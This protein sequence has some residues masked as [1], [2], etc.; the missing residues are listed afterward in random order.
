MRFNENLRNLRREKDMSQEALAC[1]M[2][3]SR[4]TISKWENGTAMPDLK[5]L[6]ELA[7]YFSVSMDTLLGI[8]A[9]SSSEKP[10]DSD[11]TDEGI[12]QYIN[13]LLAY[14][15]I[16]QQSQNKK[17]IKTFFIALAAVVIIFSIALIIFYNNFSEQ[18]TAL[19]VR[20]I[21]V[22]SGNS[23]YDYDETADNIDYK[24]IS[25]HEDKPYTANVHFEYNPESYPKNSE[26]YYLIPQSDSDA[27][28]IDAV[29]N[30]GVFTADADVDITLNKEIYLCIDDVNTVE[31]KKIV[32]SFVADCFAVTVLTTPF[33]EITYG[34][35]NNNMQALTFDPSFTIDNTLYLYK[36][37]EGEFTSA[38]LVAACSGKEQFSKVLTF[39]KYTPEGDDTQGNYIVEIPAVSF[40]LPLDSLPNEIIYISLTDENGTEYKYYPCLEDFNFG[41]DDDLCE[42]VFNTDSGQITVSNASDSE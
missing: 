30:N 37:T 42:I 16:N 13:E 17:L 10:A 4:Q 6:T 41:I 39:K 5:K 33:A 29:L 36:G 35:T 23:N 9:Q 14:S 26:I 18:I 27:Q 34:L 7:E 24:L 3:V 32:T 40:S 20:P 28:R 22:Q 11:F 19:S 2:N 21:T 8:Y 1:D 12:K 31:R 38:K 15:Q 25:F